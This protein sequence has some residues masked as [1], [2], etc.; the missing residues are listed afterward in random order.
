[1]AEKFG[2]GGGMRTTKGFG[3]LKGVGGGRGGGF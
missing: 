3:S 2:G 1:M